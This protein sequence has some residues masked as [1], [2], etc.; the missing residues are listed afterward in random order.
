MWPM[1]RPVFARELMEAG[2]A[3]GPWAGL[4]NDCFMT[5]ATDMGTYD[6]PEPDDPYGFPSPEAAQMGIVISESRII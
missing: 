1:R 6:N 2:F 5:N 3:T 4:Y